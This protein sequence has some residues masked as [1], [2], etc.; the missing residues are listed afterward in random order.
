MP[1]DVH[2]THCCVFHGCKY[3][4]EDCP[5]ETRLVKQA[6]TCEQCED[7]GF[8]SVDDV[9]TVDSPNYDLHKMGRK[10]LIK[11]CIRLREIVNGNSK[12]G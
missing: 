5:V 2:R 3:G 9:P 7:D 6:Y 11:E 8:E 1:V 4:D 10:E 12:V